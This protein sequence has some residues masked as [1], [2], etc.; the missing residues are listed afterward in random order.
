M[1]NGTAEQAQGNTQAVSLRAA[2]IPEDEA[3]LR[4]LYLST[5]R[6]EMS[7]WGWNDAQQEIFARMQFNARQQS[8]V[9]QYPEAVYKIILL[10][11]GRAG[12]LIVAQR[13]DEIR[14]VDIALLPEHR[15]RGI[16]SFIVKELF[17]EADAAGKI[18]RLH[19]QRENDAAR[20]L[21]ER[22]GFSIT[23]ENDT[24]LRM[25]RPPRRI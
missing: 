15:N 21:Y 18:L 6:E 17:M 20:R 1:E 25:E 8:Y 7:A 10:G 22:L 3:F 19:V 14:L 13:D 24:Y 23:N 11:G 2:A 4:E 16:G 9:M 12:S 5:R